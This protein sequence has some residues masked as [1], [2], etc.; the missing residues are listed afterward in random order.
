[1][2]SLSEEV[3]KGN[4]IIKRLQTNLKNSDA[5]LKLRN[6]IAQEQEKTLHEK[7]DALDNAKEELKI[8]REDLEKRSVE[9]EK[10]KKE[11]EEK[12]KEVEEAKAKIEKNESLI[13]WLNKQATERQLV[14][15]APPTSFAS[16]S[17][18]SGAV[19]T[20]GPLTMGP[21]TLGTGPLVRFPLN[22]SPP[23]NHPRPSLPQTTLSIYP[24][25]PPP[26]P[27]P[28]TGLS[29]ET[30]FHQR[31]HSTA[32]VGHS[33]GNGLS[34]AFPFNAYQP[35]N[36]SFGALPENAPLPI[37]TGAGRAPRQLPD[38]A[39]IGNLPKPNDSDGIKK[40]EDCIDFKYLQ[41]EKHNN[42]N[43]NKNTANNNNPK[44]SFGSR[45]NVTGGITPRFSVPK[46][47]VTASSYFPPKA[48]T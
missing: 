20:S 17:L 37:S 41:S 38:T 25:A 30:P 12:T 40:P 47:A 13:T 32:I 18:K 4:E 8:V 39:N 19:A 5:K 15:Q 2:K 33:H 14:S 7:S 9:L 48:K 28:Y 24:Q 42:N 27:Q 21:P 34:P 10:C 44:K 36:P 43:N 22:P 35:S 3:Q 16:M 26:M 23:T 11:A 29:A 31:A 46:P 6:Q 1:V 45:Y